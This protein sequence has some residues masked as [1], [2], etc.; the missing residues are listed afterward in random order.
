MNEYPCDRCGVIDPKYRFV[1]VKMDSEAEANE[2]R[3]FGVM[4]GKCLE[5]LDNWLDN[6]A[7]EGIR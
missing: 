4:C 2:L 6:F 1:K 3:W 7:M 5:T